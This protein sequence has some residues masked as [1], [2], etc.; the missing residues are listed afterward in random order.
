MSRA[1]VDASVFITLAAIGRLDCLYTLDRTIHVPAAV[2]AEIRDDPAATA[3]ANAREDGR[4]LVTDGEQAPATGEENDLLRHAASHL[5]HG[6]LDD[7]WSGDVALLAFGMGGDSGVV[8]ITD[9]KPLRKAC[10]A[11]GV[12]L[13]A[14]IGVLVAAVERDGLDPVEAKDSLEAMDAVGARMSARLFRRAERRIG[15]AK[16]YKDG[17]HCKD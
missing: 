1:F 15:D 13:S 9:D 17:T 12:E 10:K 4:V 5:G 7:G 2:A 11:L 8:V 6:P 16:E 14:S 3:L